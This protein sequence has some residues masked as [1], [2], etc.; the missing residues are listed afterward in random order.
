MRPFPSKRETENIHAV[1]HVL[2]SQFFSSSMG[3]LSGL[4]QSDARFV[5]LDEQFPKHLERS[6]LDREE[7]FVAILPTVR[8]RFAKSKFA[9]LRTN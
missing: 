6:V 3:E 8:T 7:S 2:L 5:E 4:N 9:Q 1:S